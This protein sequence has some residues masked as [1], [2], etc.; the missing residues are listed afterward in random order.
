MQGMM[1]HTPLSIIEVLKIRC[2]GASRLQVWF[3]S[4]PKGISTVPVILKLLV[5]QHNWRMLWPPWG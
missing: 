1:M 3:L 2:R 4:E 5:A